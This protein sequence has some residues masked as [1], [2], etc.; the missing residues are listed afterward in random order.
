[1]N[2]KYK[3][4]Y[5]EDDWLDAYELQKEVFELTGGFPRDE[6]FSLISQ[7]H[8]SSNSVVAN[9]AEA[10]GRFYFLDKVRVLYIV[11]GEIEETQ[12]H[13]IVSQSR[14]YINKD[15]ASELVGRYEEVKKKINGKISDFINKNK[16]K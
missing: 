1:M 15:R 8:R 10:H 11:R 5:E 13:I 4:F 3:K 6:K 2:K 14:N 12:S 9:I 7:I 16:E